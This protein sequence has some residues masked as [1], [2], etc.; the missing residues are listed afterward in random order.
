VVFGNKLRL[1]RWI[2]LFILTA[3]LVI[4]GVGAT[5]LGKD[6]AH[7]PDSVLGSVLI[8]SSKFLGACQVRE[9]IQ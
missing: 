1:A 3:G 9:S 7:A 2:G 6:R 8:V 4:V 5:L